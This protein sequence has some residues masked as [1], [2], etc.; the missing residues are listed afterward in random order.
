MTLAAATL[1]FLAIVGIVAATTGVG[2]LWLRGVP[3]LIWA[4]LFAPVLA[5]SVTIVIFLISGAIASIVTGGLIA[6][7]TL[8]ALWVTVVMAPF[9]TDLA[10]WALDRCQKTGDAVPTPFRGYVI[11][12]RKRANDA[13]YVLPGEARTTLTK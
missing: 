2:Y 1:A 5:W 9:V 3:R 10:A 4:V 7:S 11:D 13:A 12:R 8:A 6:A